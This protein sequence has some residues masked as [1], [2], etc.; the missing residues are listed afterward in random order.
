MCNFSWLLNKCKKSPHRSFAWSISSVVHNFYIW[1]I[2]K[3]ACSI[4]MHTITNPYL[5][6]FLPIRDYN[7]N[8]T[9]LICMIFFHC[10]DELNLGIFFRFLAKPSENFLK[11]PKRTIERI[12]EIWNC[13]LFL[14]NQTNLLECINWVRF[15]TYICI[16]TAKKKHNLQRFSIWEDFS[17]IPGAI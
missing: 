8:L 2:E 10:D 15:P 9:L 17:R 4:F 6:C 1:S 13:S 11:V 16:T 7:H 12:G 3:W 14:N 5:Q